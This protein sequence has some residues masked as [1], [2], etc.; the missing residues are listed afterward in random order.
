MK[1]RLSLALTVPLS[2][3]AM[4]AAHA[5]V[6]LADP[7]AA[8][9]AYY[10]SF[11]RIGHGC[12]GSATTAL[13]VELPEAITAA[14]PQPKPGWTVEIEHAPL[15]LPVKGEGGKMLTER[16]K[17]ITW[18][19]GP[20]PDD[21]WDQFGISAKLPDQPG[22]LYFPAIQTCEVGEA[23]WVEVPAA[24]KPGRLAHPA[25]SLEIAVGAGGDDMA[26]MDMS[27]MDRGGGAP[28][29][30]ATP[31][32]QKPGRGRGVR[33]SDAWIAKPPLGA[34]TASGYLRITNDGA[35]PDTLLSAS[36]PAADRLELHSMTMDGGIMRMRPMTGGLVVPA[37]KS[38]LIAA[39]T[40]FH[41]MVIRPKRPLKAGDR[42]PATLRFARTGNVSVIFLVKPLTSGGGGMSMP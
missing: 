11:F 17:A 5:H 22:K 30:P 7:R 24:D 10:V 2:L 19:G 4:G 16:V 38:I 34:P 3:V 9:G 32:L 36:T 27:G 15:S 25:P 29:E 6:T 28:A 14:R 41:F 31:A 35:T 12:A 26:G 37:G 39:N 18:R 21:Q 20:L 13:R 40:G 42:V 23:R 8:P 1:S 33:L